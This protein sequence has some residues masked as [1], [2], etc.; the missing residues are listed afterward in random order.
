MQRRDSNAHNINLEAQ[1]VVT[2][3][4][5]NPFVTFRFSIVFQFDATCIYR[6]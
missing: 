6:V 5:Q 3:M 1:I 2:K 4:R